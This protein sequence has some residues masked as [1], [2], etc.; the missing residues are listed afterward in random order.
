MTDKRYQGVVVIIPAYNESGK[1]GR[2]VKRIPGQFVE[3]IVVIDDGSSDDT[4][5]EAEQAGATVVIHDVNRGVG[6]AIRTGIRY[7]LR[8]GYSV[9]VVMGGDDQDNPEEMG[10]LLDLVFDQD[11]DFVQG[12]RYLPGGATRNIPWFRW[13]TTGFYSF[14]FKVL[15][16]FPITDGT[17]GFRAFRLSLTEE[18][19]IRLDQKWLDT[20]ELEPY[21][22]YRAISC[23]FRVTEAPVTKRYPPGKE[24]FTKM[25]PFLDWWRIL[26]PLFFLRLGL[27]T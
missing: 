27:K 20:Y 4:R 22:Y 11:Y 7:G 17:N 9:A 10:R 25:I 23:G 3:E 2:V 19:A 13:I 16:Q 8:R 6:A 18:D 5:Q 12:S 21:L 15:V 14:L 26:R 1:I 24:G